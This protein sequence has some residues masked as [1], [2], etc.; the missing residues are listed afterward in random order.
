MISKYLDDLLELSTVKEGECYS[1]GY[2]H[3]RVPIFGLYL[4]AK[5]GS[6]LERVEIMAKGKF[7]L[8]MDS[9]NY[10]QE[11]RSKFFELLEKY[12]KENGLPQT[13]EGINNMNGW[14][15]KSCCNYMSN[16]SKLLKS[17]ASVRDRQTGDYTIF[18]LLSLDEEQS[19]QGEVEKT[20]DESS[21]ES[22]CFF[23]QWFNE[24]KED[25]LTKK[26]LQYLENEQTVLVNNRARMNKTISERVYRYY[27]EDTISRYRI[28]K[29]N[30]K[31]KVLEDLLFNTITDRQFMYKLVKYMRKEKWITEYVYSLSFETCKMITNTCKRKEVS[32]KKINVIEIEDELRNLYSF[33][34]KTL[35]KLEKDINFL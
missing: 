19:L 5:K 17:G 31:L 28:D 12:I 1:L 22:F 27:S 11:V 21:K 4:K 29:L 25:I 30:Q 2:Y 23:R 35:K 10:A 15:Y 14:L 9:E 6:I 24:N 26:Q 32:Y 3:N 18:K 8:E 20:L 13:N 33:I 34:L 16:L 7:K